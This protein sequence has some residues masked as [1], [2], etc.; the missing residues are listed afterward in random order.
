MLPVAFSRPIRI[1]NQKRSNC[2]LALLREA[3]SWTNNTGVD[4][5]E[6]LL[7]AIVV[8]GGPAGATAANKLAKSGASV[9]VCEREKF[10][11]FH[12][13][14][15]LLPTNVPLLQELG[16]EDAI[17]A[18]G[19]VTKHGAEV[20]SADGEAR[21]AIYFRQAM[22]PL[23][24]TTFQV[25]RATFDEIL[26]R[27]AETAGAEVREE[28][29][30][31]SCVREGD[32]WRVVLEDAS[33]T[34]EQTCRWIID[35]SGRD[36][37]LANQNRSK[38][39]LPE[40]KR[41]SFFAHYDHVWR[42]EGDADGNTVLIRTADGWFW[43]IPVSATRTSVG[44]VLPATEVRRA[45]LRPEALLDQAIERAPEMAR[46]M[47]KAVRATEVQGT[48]D[49]SYRTGEMTGPGFITAGDAYAFLDPIFSTGV[50]LA[51]RGGAG[52][53]D[54][55]AQ[56]LKRPA[57][58]ERYLRR[59]ARRE[60]RVQRHFRRLIQ[61]FYDPGFTDVFLRPVNAFGL[62]RAVGTYVSGAL[63]QR[64]G[65]RLRLEIVLTVAR[66]Q[67]RLGL[68]PRIQLPQTLA[69]ETT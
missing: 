17:R 11:R 66:L 14:E 8:G 28:T 49:F 56:C 22:C 20:I 5:S 26:L 48:S 31:K 58:S 46:R 55:V 12:I 59:F 3:P 52:A 27:A 62:R 44:V 39:M 9:L 61:Y 16:V 63:P 18:A 54:T 15:S 60:E 38:K 10:P 37:F 23:P 19:S 29:L 53:A 40:H 64:L 45:G 50:W 33:G 6:N 21:T 41:V 1:C 30:V 47:R 42:A 2:R 32:R 57:R 68:V 25:E 51:M 7:D 36:T 4:T 35:G 69:P 13:G 67:P 34:T 43:L 65:P 24:E